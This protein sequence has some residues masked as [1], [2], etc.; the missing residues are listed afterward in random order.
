MAFEHVKTVLAK[1]FKSSALDKGRRENKV[2][3]PNGA[4]L[5]SDEKAAVFVTNGKR[6]ACPE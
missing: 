1:L 5:G 3:P 4:V 6:G 2:I